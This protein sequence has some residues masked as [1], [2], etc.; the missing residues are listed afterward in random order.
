MSAEPYHL[1]FSK[2]ALGDLRHF[3]KS[4][5]NVILEAVDEQ[6]LHE[7]LKATRNRKPL[8][9]NDLSSWEMRVGAFRVFYDVDEEQREVTIKAVGAKEHN[10]LRI[11][12]K[13]YEL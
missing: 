4:Q 11:R 1:V 3:A 2:N 10:R 7:P 5:Q 13:D 12:G 8:R 6:L 9:P